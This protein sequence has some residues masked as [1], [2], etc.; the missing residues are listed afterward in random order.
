MIECAKPSSKSSLVRA[1]VAALS[2][3]ACVGDLEPAI[4][5]VAVASS[6]AALQAAGTELHLKVFEVDSGFDERR[7]MNF[8]LP[9]LN[10]LFGNTGFRIVY[11]GKQPA[12]SKVCTNTNHSEVAKEGNSHRDVIPL[13]YCN[14][15]NFSVGAG[16]FVDNYVV[17]NETVGLDHEIGHYL[18]LGHTFRDCWTASDAEADRLNATGSCGGNWQSVE[19]VI[20]DQ[21]TAALA[22]CPPA[23][24]D[25]PAL[26]CGSL[27]AVLRNAPATRDGYLNGDNIDDTPL[28]LH[29]YPE[30]VDVCA[31]GY[32]VPLK[33]TLETPYSA[34]NSLDLSFEP[35]LHNRMDY[36]DCPAATPTPSTQST[37]E[38]P[39]A[40]S[41]QQIAKMWNAL[42]TNRSALLRLTSP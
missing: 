30:G 9:E 39:D 20:F 19:T 21:I 38:G 8:H 13:F 37:P 12:S 24:T 40:Y 3:S 26:H 23:S 15:A 41:P 11:D 17:W 14:N 6:A 42:N 4:D 34:I 32:R 16:A 1:C 10:R 36:F 25:D 18:S 31:P 5:G 29:V 33:M 7:F 35:G 22:E 27:E 28:A 2:I